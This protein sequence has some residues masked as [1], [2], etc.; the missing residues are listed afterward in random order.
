LAA[1]AAQATAGLPPLPAD[2]APEVVEQYR[3]AERNMNEFRQKQ[4][5]RR[6][7]EAKD[8]TAIVRKQ[9]AELEALRKRVGTSA[10]ANK[11]DVNSQSPAPT[12]RAANGVEIPRQGE[13]A[14]AV[15]PYTQR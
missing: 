7:V 15:N 4:A 2:A 14:E 9:A 10:K 6:D 1:K 13:Y 8:L 11:P 5:F 3:V 12:Q